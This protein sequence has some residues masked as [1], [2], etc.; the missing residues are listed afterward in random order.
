MISF[1]HLYNSVTR[2]LDRIRKEQG[3]RFYDSVRSLEQVH[4]IAGALARIART[5]SIEIVSCAEKFDLSGV[6]IE[7]GKCIDDLLIERLFGVTVSHK[8]DKNQREACRCIESQDIGQYNTCTHE[9]IY[10]YAASNKKEAHKNRALHDPKSAFL[11][12]PIP[13]RT[14]PYPQ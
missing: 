7:H 2:N 3:V 10:C 5:N 6:G 14:P 1:V 12:C 4:R 9:C 13:S 8:K 11:I